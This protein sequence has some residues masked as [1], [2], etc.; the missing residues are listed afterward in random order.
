MEKIKIAG[1]LS[2]VKI[3]FRSIFRN[4]RRTGFCVIAVGTA[5]FFIV[6]YSSMINGMT[7]SMNEVVRVFETGDVRAVSKDFEA[8]SEYNP[9]QY[10]VAEGKSLAAVISET[11][12]LPGVKAAFPRIVSYASLLE[13]NVKHAVLWG[14]NINEEIKTNNFNLTERND[15]LVEGRYPAP[16]SNECAIGR[17]FAEKSGL[18]TGD[19][20]PL[21]TMSSQFSDKMWAPE[22]TGIFNFDY[23]KADGEFI[24]VDYERLSRLLLLRDA[25]QQIVVYGEN[26][27]DSARIASGMEKILNPEDSV[28]EW[29]DQYWI[30]LMNGYQPLYFCIYLIFLIVACLLIINTVTMIIHERIKE[31][32]MM[33]SLGMTRFEIVEVFF[34]ESV[35]LSMAGAFAGVLAG[36]IL[37][38]ILQN[39]PIRWTAIA[40]ENT[41]ASMPAANAIFVQF[42]LL[43]LAK[44]W[45]L[46]VLVA[47][48]FT[49]FPSLKSA[50]VRPVEALRR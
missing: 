44:N 7:N 46:G 3:A 48:L 12:A 34:F 2:L 47:S 6:F 35:F 20:I 45:L 26:P 41:F 16:G 24:I 13:N 49:L 38:G 27:E 40:G 25:A 31:I 9:V 37:V 4:K 32:G 21:K 33:G 39:F 29:K 22:I 18:K 8:E 11:E 5:V 36:G 14:L 15:G 23:A 50:F 1:T 42:S 28:T 43:S 30:A 10:P 19:S 17:R